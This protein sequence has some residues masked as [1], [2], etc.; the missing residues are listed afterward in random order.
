MLNKVCVSAVY[1]KQG[2]TTSCLNKNRSFSNSINRINTCLLLDKKFLFVLEN[3]K[4][5]YLSK[6]IMILKGTWFPF[7]YQ[8]YIH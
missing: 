5:A 8:L 3:Y 1:Y 6:S 4:Q 2:D 7:T